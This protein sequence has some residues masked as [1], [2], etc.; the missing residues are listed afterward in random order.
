MAHEIERKF[1]L[2]EPPAWVNSVVPTPIHQ[3][4][5]AVEPNGREVRLRRAGTVFSLTVKDGTGLT[6]RENEV[7]LSE[8]QFQALWPGTAGRRLRKKRYIHRLP[9][10]LTMELDA[11]QEPLAGLWIGELEFPDEDTAY[12]YSPPD[13]LGREVTH[14]TLFKNQNLLRFPTLEALREA[15]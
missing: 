8:E 13:W 3:G 9:E 15:L 6:R 5:L 11:Y 14:E 4:Y 7:P 2:P 12:A 10:G 1:W